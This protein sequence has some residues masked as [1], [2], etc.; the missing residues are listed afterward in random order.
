MYTSLVLSLVFVLAGCSVIPNQ[1]TVT[2]EAFVADDIEEAFGDNT[3]SPTL[4]LP[5]PESGTQVIWKNEDTG[6]ASTLR[7]AQSP[8][9]LLHRY[10]TEEG[11]ERTDYLFCL[12]CASPVSTFDTQTY[13]T[14]FPLSVGKRVVFTHSRKRG[15]GSVFVLTHTVT[16][17]TSGT[18]TFAEVKLPVLIVTEDIVN[19]TNGWRGKRIFWYA[20]SLRANVRVVDEARSDGKTVAYQ[21]LEYTPPPFDMQAVM[22]IEGEKTCTHADGVDSHGKAYRYRACHTPDRRLEAFAEYA[23]KTYSSTGTW[24]AAKNSVT[25]QWDN[26]N[27]ISGTTTFSRNADGTYRGEVENGGTLTNMVFVRVGKGKRGE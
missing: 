7:Y 4:P 22:P 3:T 1:E 8:I 15:D 9:P 11:T 5:P 13:R 14:L 27:W 2:E 18:V 25:V 19:E 21:L 12:H 26:P 23:D 10:L 24:T 6:A 17:E 20:P 16:V